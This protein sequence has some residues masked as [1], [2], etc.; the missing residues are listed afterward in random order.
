METN[1]NLLNVIYENADMG[2]IG[3]D[4]VLEKTNNPKLQK[5]LLKERKYY[6]KVVKDVKKMIKD[7]HG[8]VNEVSMFAK[9]SS[10]VYSDIKLINND[11]DK[12]IIQMMIEGIYKSIGILKTKKIEYNN[13]SEDIKMYLDKFINKIEKDINVLMK[14]ST[15]I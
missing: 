6:L 5:E 14:L 12:I 15:I 1:T 9:I 13:V 2:I 4:K 8:S 10:E 7:N 3:I 11:S